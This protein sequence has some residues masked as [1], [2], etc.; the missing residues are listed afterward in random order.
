[1]Y[2]TQ[3]RSPSNSRI[4]QQPLRPESLSVG[5]RRKI[6][7]GFAA[8]WARIEYCTKQ[9]VP[10]QQMSKGFAS[11]EQ[12]V[13]LDYLSPWNVLALFKARRSKHYRV[14][15]AI[16]GTLMT[17]L[18]ILISTGLFVSQDEVYP[19]SSLS[20]TKVFGLTEDFDP[21][22][23]DI[24]AQ[25]NLNGFNGSH[26][27]PVGS[28]EQFAFQPFYLP[29]NVS[30]G[31]LLDWLMAVVYQPPTDQHAARPHYSALVEVFS[32]DLDCQP[33]NLASFKNGYGSASVP[34]CD[35]TWLSNGQQVTNGKH[36]LMQNGT[37]AARGV[38]S[39]S[40][41]EDKQRFIICAM[42]AKI[43][44]YTD[45]K[46]HGSFGSAGAG[47]MATIFADPNTC[48]ICLPRY[49]IRAGDVTMT[50]RTVT[51]VN[52]SFPA[53]TR[54][55]PHL[56]LWQMAVS[57][58]YSLGVIA[59][60]NY[61]GTLYEYGL[62]WGNA[63]FERL[64]WDTNP[65]ISDFTTLYDANVLS[66]AS[67]KTFQRINAQVALL[68]FMLLGN[69]T[70][71][72]VRYEVL[73]P[74]FCVAPG[75]FYAMEIF[76]SVLTLFLLC[77]A[78]LMRKHG[79]PP[80]NPFTFRGL[81]NIIDISPKL[82]LLLRDTGHSSLKDLRLKLAHSYFRLGGAPY[83][84]KDPFS[85]DT[86]HRPAVLQRT[87]S[88][89]K[90]S[91]TRKG[92]A[93]LKISSEK[94]L[95]SQTPM[96]SKPES[97]SWIPFVMKPF[98]CILLCLLP[99][100][101]VSTLVALLIRSNKSKGIVDL[102]LDDPH[103]HYGWTLLPA[104]I[105]FGLTVIYG[106]LDTALQTLQPFQN[107]RHGRTAQDSNTYTKD[108]G[109]MIPI[110]AFV[111]A[112][113]HGH[114]VMVAATLTTLCA[115]F[116]PI[117]INGLF[118]PGPATNTYQGINTKIV[119]W[120]N[121][122]D[123]RLPTGP[124]PYW[125]GLNNSDP[126]M[127]TRIIYSNASYPQW[128][129]SELALAEIDLADDTAK[130]VLPREGTSGSSYL[131]S[132]AVEIPALRAVMNCTSQAYATTRRRPVGRASAP[133]YNLLEVNLTLPDICRQTGE[134]PSPFTCSD[135]TMSTQWLYKPGIIGYWARSWPQVRMTMDVFGDIDAE[136]NPKNLTVMTC[137]PYIETLQ[138]EANFDFPSFKLA[139]RGVLD[140]T[141]ETSPVEAIESTRKFFNHDS[142]W[143]LFGDSFVD[144]SFDRV[145]P[146][147]NLTG[148]PSPLASSDG[149][150]QALFQ[151]KEAI[152]DPQSLL[153][154][155]NVEKL[156]EAVE[157][158]YRIIMAQTLN[159]AQGRRIPVSTELDPSQPP[160]PP[161]GLGMIS[162][163]NGKRLYQSHIATYILVALLVIMLICAVFA[164][165]TFRPK[166]LVT[167]E[168]TS[169]AA[170]MSLLMDYNTTAGH[171][172]VAQEAK[173]IQEQRDLR[174]K[175]VVQMKMEE[176]TPLA[177]NT[178]PRYSQIRRKPV[179]NQTLSG[180]G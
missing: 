83:R 87:S 125:L 105:F 68:N 176:T 94:R 175:D 30:L 169:L 107:L 154:P 177:S 158:L 140:D 134:D 174:D 133:E 145:L 38:T 4:R 46:P 138:A 156:I 7:T 48:L 81:S 22:A 131:P 52:I 128:T 124:R 60:R 36:I 66:T 91:Q 111:H 2:T 118:S 31:T 58:F 168:P 127:T 132:I 6:L 95:L 64:L 178:G 74:R 116:F 19:R 90:A 21:S 115:P 167:M 70:N 171:A 15:M 65:A 166:G 13:L 106:L 12:S 84:V 170:R 112:F 85:I 82:V 123:R 49:S 102:P 16:A 69:D 71:V 161:L 165:A 122:T 17:Q 79:I 129:Y 10:W 163:P 155:A 78:F 121:V 172:I 148:Y 5:K 77:L 34:G 110:Q 1:M 164:L 54:Q 80:E 150:F 173:V 159:T 53:T 126:L 18:L 101:L 142:F 37:C 33:S 180:N 113:R 144:G 153:G 93:C 130:N 75:V 120:F 27:Y 86:H 97:E 157:H 119:G 76:L 88:I 20:P 44:Q 162:N 99:V 51:D 117:V 89:R 57:F 96:T 160:P 25:F 139:D 45:G 146:S 149:F 72:R 59:V 109:G 14:A 137:M 63:P 108:F 147:V 11:P 73:E 47:P 23:V 100:A 136:G 55:V 28:T 152:A 114:H 32:S 98:G 56:S 43:Q 40:N 141:L 50:G 41:D 151:G 9:V 179:P 29:Y 67:R 143:T 62:V 26:E 104:T 103:V 24:R 39:G 42:D 92:K 135:G 35:I 61:L 8:L 3:T